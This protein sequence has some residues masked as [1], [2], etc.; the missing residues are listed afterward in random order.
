SNAKNYSGYGGLYK[1]LQKQDVQKALAEILSVEEW[2]S[3]RKSASTAY[4]T[5]EPIIRYCWQIVE[6][7]G[8]SSGEILEPTCGVGA[9]FEYMP[10]AIRNNSNITGI[11]LEKV[12]AHIASAL[13]DDIEIINDGYQNHKAEYD[14]IIGN[15]P[16]ATFSVNDRHFNDLSELKIHHAFLA[17]SMRLLR[18]GGLCVMVVPCYCLDSS[19]SHAR[20]I[21]AKEAELVCSYRLPDSLFSDAKVTVD[22]VVFQKKV[23]PKNQYLGL[24]QIELSCGYKDVISDYYIEHQDH[25]LGELEKYEMYLTKEKR[26][27][28]GLKVTGSM[29]EVEKRLPELIAQLEPVYQSN[30]AVKGVSGGV[31]K[32]KSASN[33]MASAKVNNSV[34]GLIFD[35]QQRIVAL[36][37]ELEEIAEELEKINNQKVA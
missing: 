5:P 23:K 15:P 12:S 31:V 3:L 8:F 11:E 13:Y 34:K 2:E 32:F 19:S 37:V 4:Y 25:I 35:I 7:L 6:Q 26:T 24:T 20:D 27:R 21:I 10:E 33:T 29:E 16:Y 22:I 18:D 30:S 36:S 9:F 28:Q 1:E 17:R 14:L